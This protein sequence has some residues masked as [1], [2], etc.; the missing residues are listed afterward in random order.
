VSAESLP[1]ATRSW[2]GLLWPSETDSGASPA[3]LGAALAVGVLAALIL[4]PQIT[5]SAYLVVGVGVF[6]VAVGTRSGR[7]TRLQFGGVI[8]T[9]S[10]LAVTIIRSSPWLVV[11]CM[12][13]AWL[14]GSFSLVGGRTWTGV[15][16]GALA[17]GLAPPRA[18]RWARRTLAALQPPAA[19]SRRVW[20][21]VAV[22]AGLV[23]LFGALFATADAAYAALL[24]D[25]VPSLDIGDVLWRLFVLVGVTATAIVAAYLSHQ[26]PATDAL[27]PGSGRAVRRWEWIVPLAVLDLL[28]LS[29]VLVQFSVL[30]GGQAH[31]LATHDL[32]YA[33]YA[34]QGFWQLLVVTALT[35]A[36]VAV[37][38]RVAPRTTPADVLVVRVLLAALCLLA[39]VVV[40]SALHRMSI[41]EQA[42]GYTRLRLFVDTVELALGGT[43]ILILAA[44]V[45]MT[46]F[47]LPRAALALASVALL[48]L[49]VANPDAYIA[50]HNVA[51]FER[52]GNID[53]NY[54][55]TLSPDAVP[56]L[57][58]LSADLRNCALVHIATELRDHEDPWYN[59][60][61]ARAHARRLLQTHPIANCQ[62]A[63][64]D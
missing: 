30:F 15:V 2:L 47:W 46:G 64:S 28:F 38:V 14:V 44:G 54:L 32:T 56:A 3:V 45:R 35:L 52:T 1:P 51:R 37:A 17:G 20:L 61:L 58:R 9:M 31:V 34:R 57:L 29:F 48:G 43:F 6:A 50:D 10:L 53:V 18:A 5:G 33:E 39:L 13:A 36:V 19:R 55:A 21:V 49:A 11:L 41:Y 60:N 26:P 63:P 23:A 40:A 42:Y 16:V 24:D 4:R 62:A 59:L 27:A 25:A 22:T 7:L 8:L 12:L